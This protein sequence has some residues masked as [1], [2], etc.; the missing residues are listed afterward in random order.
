MIS[1]RKKHYGASTISLLELEAWCERNLL[2]P[3]DNDKPWVLKYQIEYEDEIN[4]YDD[5]GNG[6]HNAA[7]DDDDKNKFRFF[8]TTKRLL[9]YASISN[10]I[11][12][13]AIYK[14]IWQD[15]LV[16]LLEPLI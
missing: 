8:V 12:I 2:I 6:D 5:N 7:D 9:F 4:N 16:V 11:H 1:L 3:D 10:K 13:D 15:F 14:L